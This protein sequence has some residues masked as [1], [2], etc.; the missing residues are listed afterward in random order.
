[1]RVRPAWI[2]SALLAAPACGARSELTLSTGGVG[3][4]GTGS[5]PNEPIGGLATGGLATGGLATG[6]LA[7]GGSEP[8]T[9][10]AAGAGAPAEEICN[11]IDDDGDGDIDEGF[12]VV[13]C[14]VGACRATVTVCRGDER[15]V[16]GSRAAETCNGIDDDCDGMVDEGLGLHPEEIYPLRT[17]EL[18]TGDCSTCG[19]AFG[20]VA[21][22]GPEGLVALWQLGFDGSRPEPNAVIG[23]LSTAFAT[24]TPE[25]LL[26]P[27]V[28][29]GFRVAV[30]ADR[31]AVTTSARWGTS[32][33][34]ALLWLDR[35]GE[36]LGGPDRVMGDDVTSGS[37]TP[38]VVW[39]GSHFLVSWCSYA[40]FQPNGWPLMVS[41]YD[42]EGA[43]VR[44][45]VLVE[46][47]RD[48][49]LQ[50]LSGSGDRVLAMARQVSSRRG[51]TYVLD[52]EGDLV[53]GTPQP[54]GSADQDW[55]RGQAS[56]TPD[57]WLVFG[58]KLAMQGYTLASVDRDGSTRAVLRSVELDGSL[59]AV[60]LAPA[61][62]GGHLFVGS[63]ELYGGPCER[64]VQRLDDAGDVLDEWRGAADETCFWDPFLVAVG[65]EAYVVYAEYPAG[66]L[67]N[68]VRAMR[69]ACGT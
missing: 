32:D 66:D 4:G 25:V 36:L 63:T 16:Q 11:G 59:H 7:T 20:S 17:T 57:G 37:A 21:W 62:G 64:F 27:N 24:R 3:I 6:G 41:A 46:D 12:P 1:M 68:A 28:T 39:S 30:G 52:G 34:P 61:P 40:V 9:G 29:T 14:G 38:D 47:G 23:G 26:E 50:R 56:P 44:Q 48:M 60:H 5:A 13:E 22:E 54:L 10:G 2:L 33:H 53:T 45:T 31:V 18:S 19:W 55:L 43:L 58:A 8:L 35:A 42:A 49:E 67:S 15:C 51:V 65:G 69:L